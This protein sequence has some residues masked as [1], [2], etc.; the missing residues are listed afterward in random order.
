[1][2]YPVYVLVD[3]QISGGIKDAGGGYKQVDLKAMS[4]FTFDQDNGTIKDIPKKWRDLEG[5][6][7]ILEGELWS[8]ASA[9]PHGASVQLCYSIAKCCFQGPPQVQHF[10]NLAPPSNGSIDFYS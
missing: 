7:V 1:I 4:L 2:G 10:V 6:K 8:P 9:G 3:A 5:Q